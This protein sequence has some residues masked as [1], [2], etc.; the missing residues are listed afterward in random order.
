MSNNA[1]V[2]DSNPV[3]DVNFLGSVPGDNN[4]DGAEALIPS[5]LLDSVSEHGDDTDESK[6]NL[7]YDTI[8]QVPSFLVYLLI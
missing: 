8:L 2:A 3:I 4:G 6:R 1:V 5:W 7:F